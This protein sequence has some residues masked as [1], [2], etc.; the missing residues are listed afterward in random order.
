MW[1][2]FARQL[3]NP[4]GLTG[5]V[6]GQMMK[7]A[8]RQPTRRAIEAL[9]IQRGH[10]VLDLGCGPGQASA[11]MLPLAAPGQVC[12]IDQSATMIGEA[13]RTNHRAVQQGRALFK[14]AAFAALPFPDAHFDR[15]LA[16]NV[17]YFWHETA[18][19]LKEIKRVLRPGGKLSIYLTS[20]R[21]MQHWKIAQAG[22]HRLFDDEEVQ[23]VLA[24]AGFTPDKIRVESLALP[25]GV[26]GILA[27]ATMD[28]A[29]IS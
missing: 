6:V 11:L 3:S 23:Y 2:A 27:I 12:G 13:N 8:N 22:T 16:S 1:H 9:D 18:P 5:L 17:M 25:G 24:E 20:A 4:E 29:T 15:V 7:L 28:L 19:I 10:D 14:Q 26:I 21:T